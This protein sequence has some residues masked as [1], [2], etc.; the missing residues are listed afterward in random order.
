LPHDSWCKC[1]E[2]LFIHQLLRKG[3]ILYANNYLNNDF[4]NE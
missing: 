2:P 4:K 1:T 3:I